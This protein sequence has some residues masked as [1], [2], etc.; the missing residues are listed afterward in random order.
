ML[1][2]VLAFVLFLISVR[3]YEDIENYPVMINTAV[4]DR[5]LI[6]K[7]DTSLCLELMF[8]K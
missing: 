3:M 4:T 7:S 5:L 8:L 1:T 6:K 2:V